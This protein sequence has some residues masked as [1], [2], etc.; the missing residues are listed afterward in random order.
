MMLTVGWGREA[1]R[2]RELQGQEIGSRKETE[3]EKSGLLLMTS[4]EKP[5]QV[6]K[7]K[8]NLGIIYWEKIFKRE[9]EFGLKFPWKLSFKDRKDRKVRSDQES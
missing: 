4:T 8:E 3:E 6:K 2:A 5:V 1:G 9:T 7:N